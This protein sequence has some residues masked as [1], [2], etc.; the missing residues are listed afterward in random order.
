MQVIFSYSKC[1]YFIH[2]AV[3]S[4]K[5]TQIDRK[6]ANTQDN[7]NLLTMTKEQVA[8]PQLLCC[9][10]PLYCFGSSFFL[11]HRVQLLFY[12]ARLSQALYF[13]DRELEMGIY[14]ESTW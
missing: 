5:E 2:T 6:T 11:S 4:T 13:Q 9:R 14:T 7:Q 12:S 1:F 3:Q 8:I 10:L